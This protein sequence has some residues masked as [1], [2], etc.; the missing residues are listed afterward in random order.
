MEGSKKSL[1]QKSGFFQ[2]LKSIKHIEII[3]AVV[4]GAIALLIYFSTFS[5]GT[6]KTAYESTSTTEYIALLESKLSS[7][8]SQIKSVGNVSVMITLSSG[9][10]YIYATNEEEKTNT[11]TSGG[12]TTTST[13]TTTEP[14]I[15]SNDLVVIKEIMPTVGGVIVVASGAGDTGVKLE[16]LK[17]IQA[18]LDVPQANIEVLVGK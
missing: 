13:T 17:A 5:G 7:V 15:I 18:L 1:L 6:N 9:P 3:M 8:L 16:I 14:I 2:R 4:L 12:S 11:N 10:E